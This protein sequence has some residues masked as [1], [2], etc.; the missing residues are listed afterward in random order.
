MHK[1]TV[2]LTGNLMERNLYKKGVVS[3]NRNR[4]LKNELLFWNIIMIV[5]RN[6]FPFDNLFHSEKKTTECKRLSPL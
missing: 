1:V 4:I 6:I 3:K 2:Y 5:I